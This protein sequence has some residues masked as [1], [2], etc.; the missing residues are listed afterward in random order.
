MWKNVC[1]FCMVSFWR[2][3]YKGQILKPREIPVFTYI[4]YPLFLLQIII[5]VRNINLHCVKSV[6]FSVFWSLFSR[7]W[8][9]CGY[10]DIYDYQ[11]KDSNDD[12]KI[13]FTCFS[14]VWSVSYTLDIL[15]VTDIKYL[16]FSEKLYNCLLT[17]TT[18]N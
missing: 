6:C 18:Q 12:F 11:S 10:R 17:H 1:A 13:D 4:I 3:W 8:T 2:Y 15:Y 16:L 14:L 7:I 9:E 5:R